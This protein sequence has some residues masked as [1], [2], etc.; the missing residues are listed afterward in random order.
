MNGPGEAAAQSVTLKSPSAPNGSCIRRSKHSTARNMLS[1]A[2]LHVSSL[3]TGLNDD[4]FPLGA[5]EASGPIDETEGR[6]RR[7]ADHDSVLSWETQGSQNPQVPEWL[8]QLRSGVQ[9]LCDGSG[10]ASFLTRQLSLEQRV[11]AHAVAAL[12]GLTHTSVGNGATKRIIVANCGIMPVRTAVRPSP[13]R[14][15]TGSSEHDYH[16]VCIHPKVVC[17]HVD[18][19]STAVSMMETFELS[20]L[21][22]TPVTFSE[23]AFDGDVP[24]FKAVMTSF[25]DA[26][27]A[28]RVLEG[29]SGVHHFGTA[30]LYDVHYG[31]KEA[32]ELFC[33]GYCNGLSVSQQ[34][35]HAVPSV[36]R[37][38]VPLDFQS[39]LSIFDQ[40]KEI[41]ASAY[42]SA[43]MTSNASG[44]RK[45][46][47]KIPNGYSCADCDKFF[48]RAAERDKHWKNVHL[49]NRPYQ[50]RQCSMGFLYPKDLDR[51]LPIH[52]EDVSM[53]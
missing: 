51:H 6:Q 25:S 20:F 11:L 12:S 2:A 49:K 42:E 19:A 32:D 39:Q 44:T 14:H 40:Q 22:P 38:S 30:Q 50:C 13:R 33:H 37:P 31:F 1:R 24:D 4:D 10:Y 21:L 52:A 17:F 47:P 27:K 16:A 45:R 35:K 8:S 23:L 15:L 7:S 29:L 18:L 28:A 48:D 26:E 34:S 5:I 36:T 9:G 3:L 43:S 41:G 46:Q 53:A